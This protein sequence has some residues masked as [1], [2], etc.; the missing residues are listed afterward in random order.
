MTTI[1]GINSD[2]VDNILF[3]DFETIY[4][5]IGKFNDNIC[6]EIMNDNGDVYDIGKLDSQGFKIKKEFF[7]GE[8]LDNEYNVLNL[9]NHPNII[10][11]HTKNKRSLILEYF[12]G[13]DLYH[14]IKRYE[15]FSEKH[16]LIIFKEIVLGIKHLH[17]KNIAHRDIKLENILISEENKVKIIDFGLSCILNN[18][19]D[20][21]LG[22]KHKV[23]T[24]GYNA[25]EVL[26]SEK[27][28]YNPFLSD[29]WSL[30][31]VLFILV[32]GCFPYNE[33]SK[34]DVNFMKLISKN[35]NTDD[36]KITKNILHL[37]YGL[38]HSEPKKPI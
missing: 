19:D 21:V 31:V 33:I 9:V 4:K 3:K 24:R 7:N 26:Q 10:K 32:T 23:G 2:E 11:F 15:K 14:I 8:H 35:F 34:N 18:K 38:C 16:A 37:I 5:N 13:T 1:Y 25:P 12:D 6:N 22:K 30:G 29:L 27:E 20:H 17:S 28:S 36:I